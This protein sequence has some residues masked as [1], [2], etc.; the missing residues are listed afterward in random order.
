MK[1]RDG[2]MVRREITCAC[3]LVYTFIAV[4][5][6]LRLPSFAAR[7]GAKLNDKRPTE[8]SENAEARPIDRKLAHSFFADIVDAP[9]CNDIGR[10]S[11]GTVWKGS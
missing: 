11:F 4:V 9:R 1:S 2:T 7:L 6:S 3:L 5:K 8:N 10:L